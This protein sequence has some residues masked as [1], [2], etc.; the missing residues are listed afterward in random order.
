[1]KSVTNF[2]AIAIAKSAKSGTL[3]PKHLTTLARPLALLSVAPKVKPHLP[4]AAGR[5][6]N[7]EHLVRD[8]LAK[9]GV[10][11]GD[12]QGKGLGRDVGGEGMFGDVEPA[13]EHKQRERIERKS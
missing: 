13:A 9:E 11:E 12:V 7:L 4:T 6:V 5:N 10:E 3:Q 8:Q 2:N 1:M